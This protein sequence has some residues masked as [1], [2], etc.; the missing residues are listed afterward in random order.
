MTLVRHGR[1]A[2]L[3]GVEKEIR[4][5]K[6]GKETEHVRR[7][8]W[9]HM[10]LDNCWRNHPWVRRPGVPVNGIIL[11]T[12]VA[13]YCLNRFILKDNFGGWF[14]RCYLNDILAGA[15][16]LSYTNLLFIAVRKE[17]YSFKTLTKI[18]LFVLLAGL[19]WEFGAPMFRKDSVTDLCDIL[20]YLIGGIAYWV[21]IR[22][23]RGEHA[24]AQEE[25][26]AVS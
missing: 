21:A 1:S 4:Q 16:I 3:T 12:C 2:K 15:V 22:I 5:P 20:A 9:M 14:L 25:E 23:T 10:G 7:E 13:V 6:R 24:G 17:K 19:F 8:K 11:V 26:S 18:L